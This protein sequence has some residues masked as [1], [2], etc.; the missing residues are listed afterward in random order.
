M[1][2]RP[3]TRNT[4][5]TAGYDLKELLVAYDVYEAALILLGLHRGG[6]QAID[7]ADGAVSATIR[8]AHCPVMTVPSNFSG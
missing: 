7:C 6:N 2:G 3:S 5:H 1:H 4:R 8:E